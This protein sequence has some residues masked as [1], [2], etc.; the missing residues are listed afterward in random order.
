VLGAPLTFALELVVLY[1]A[2]SCAMGRLAE[3]SGFRGGATLGRAVFYRK[4][5]EQSH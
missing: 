5:G 1:A 2:G 4:V 3:L